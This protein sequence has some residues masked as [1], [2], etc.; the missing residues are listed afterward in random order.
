M[1][2]IV[3][4]AI[5]SPYPTVVT[6]ATAKYTAVQYFT[7]MEDSSIGGYWSHIHEYRWSSLKEAY[8]ISTHLPR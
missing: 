8:R 4:P 5:I 6:V 7:N 3:L 1:F 2:S